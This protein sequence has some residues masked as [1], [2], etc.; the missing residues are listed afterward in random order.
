MNPEKIETWKQTLNMFNSA[1]ISEIVTYNGHNYY[2]YVSYLTPVE[3]SEN[4]TDNDIK[5]SFSVSESNSVISDLIIEA[6]DQEQIEHT[7]NVVV[8]LI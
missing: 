1:R 8:T 3:V 5:L 6:I 7:I 2:F 4:I